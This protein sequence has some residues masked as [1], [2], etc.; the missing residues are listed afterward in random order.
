MFW[1]LFLGRNG[2]KVTVCNYKSIEMI[3]TVCSLAGKVTPASCGF[4]SGECI[5]PHYP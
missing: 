2:G 4:G 1:T 5:L 3:A